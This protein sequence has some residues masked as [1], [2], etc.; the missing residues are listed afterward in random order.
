[1]ETFDWDAL[2]GQERTQAVAGFSAEETIS[3]FIWS[4]CESQRVWW[5][6]ILFWALLR[7]VFG[8]HEGTIDW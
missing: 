6:W 1:M 7:A 2:D 3:C 8:M 5:L 4:G